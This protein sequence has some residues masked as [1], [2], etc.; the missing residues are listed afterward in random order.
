MFSYSFLEFEFCSKYIWNKRVK[1][2]FSWF[3]RCSVI[4]F[5]SLLIWLSHAGSKFV[6]FK[7]EILSLKWYIL[8]RATEFYFVSFR[9]P[10][11]DCW[12]Y[13]VLVAE[14]VKI[15][16]QL[17]YSG[18]SLKSG[19]RY[20]LRLKLL[21]GSPIKTYSSINNRKFFIYYPPGG[22]KLATLIPVKLYRFMRQLD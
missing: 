15:N 18:A 12:T 10:Q 2:L 13:V 1:N 21:K 17:W 20:T 7:K 16:Q 3:Y 4:I 6:L 22:S 14:P 19:T 5:L 9:W 8:F 11:L